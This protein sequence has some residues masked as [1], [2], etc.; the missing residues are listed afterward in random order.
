MNLRERVS[1]A[2][3]GLGAAGALAEC[4]T[5]HLAAAGGF[6]ALGGWLISPWLALAGLALTTLTIAVIILRRRTTTNTAAGC[7]P[8][9]AEEPAERAPSVAA[10]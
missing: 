5:V 8:P 4:C 2:L 3:P 10:R 9:A 7:C 6:A 1:A